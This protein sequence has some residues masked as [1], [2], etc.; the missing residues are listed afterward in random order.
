MEYT[1]TQA[2]RA[3]VARATVLVEHYLDENGSR[4]FGQEEDVQDILTDLAH[5]LAYV[6]KV[7]PSR[8]FRIALEDFAKEAQG[9]PANGEGK[10]E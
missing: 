7:Y 10:E 2:N 6:E 8:T 4:G 1:M 3:R 9:L 5:F